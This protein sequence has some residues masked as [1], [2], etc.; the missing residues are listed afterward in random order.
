MSF[1]SNRGNKGTAQGHLKKIIRG[2]SPGDFRPGAR[3]RKHFVW[4]T[5][6]C[7]KHCHTVVDV[8]CTVTTYLVG[9]VFK[10][11]N[12]PGMLWRVRFSLRCCSLEIMKLLRYILLTKT[13]VFNTRLS[14]SRLA[15][16][17]PYFH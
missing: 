11:R 1:L 9:F 4:R 3:K 13:R 17:I 7:P 5:C 15:N 10:G 6:T 8:T 12:V 16:H 2:D 14:F